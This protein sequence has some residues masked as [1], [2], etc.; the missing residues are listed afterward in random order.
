MIK[1]NKFVIL[2]SGITIGFNSAVYV[3]EET[4]GEVVLFVELLSG[5]LGRQVILF[6]E[7]LPNTATEEGI[8]E[9]IA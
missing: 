6:F 9:A 7:T 8:H 1:I 5:T 4:D 2:F 3:V